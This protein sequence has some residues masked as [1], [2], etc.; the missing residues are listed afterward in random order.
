M[1]I[2][3]DF[4]FLFII[5]NHANDLYALKEKTHSEN[6]SDVLS[7]LLYRF[8]IRAEKKAKTKKINFYRFLEN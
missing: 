3:E 1:A 4:F 6:Q 5:C 2:N 8:F 7:F